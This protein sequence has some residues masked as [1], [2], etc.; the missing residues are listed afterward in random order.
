MP[1][2]ICK[3]L[4]EL[5]AKYS[6]ERNLADKKSMLLTSNQYLC[7]HFEP[8]GV[9]SVRWGED[10]HRYYLA[11]IQTSSLS[12]LGFVKQRSRRGWFTPTKGMFVVDKVKAG[13]ADTAAMA[14]AKV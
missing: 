10:L 9:N 8:A 3:Y 11:I 6:I 14:I 7:R 12:R 1:I 2:S 13:L 4:L 5:T